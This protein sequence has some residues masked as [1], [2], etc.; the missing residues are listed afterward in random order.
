[1][2][3]IERFR[4]ELYFGLEKGENECEILTATTFNI[5]TSVEKVYAVRRFSIICEDMENCD[6]EI[7]QNITKK[8]AL[9]FA[10]SNNCISKNMHGFLD[11]DG[12]GISIEFFCVGDTKK[13]MY[14]KVEKFYAYYKKLLKKEFKNCK[15]QLTYS[16]RN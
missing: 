10:K 7:W 14:K 6:T 5:R 8:I 2:E 4:F 13:D 1:M 15:V 3:K 12:A 9:K 11:I 16:K